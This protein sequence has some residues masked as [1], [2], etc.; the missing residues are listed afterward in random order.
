MQSEVFLI[1]FILFC[2]FLFLIEV[3]IVLDSVQFVAI[4]ILG[5]ELKQLLRNGGLVSRNSWI[6]L[7]LFAY[8]LSEFKRALI[9]RV[10]FRRIT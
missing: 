9:F 1:C 8:L 3:Y 10:N 2:S 7:S 5:L 6:T 4:N